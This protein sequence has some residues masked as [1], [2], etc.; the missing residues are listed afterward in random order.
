M[1]S[2]VQKCKPRPRVAIR[3]VATN[4]RYL[5]GDDDPLFDER[6]LEFCACADDKV[7]PD[8]S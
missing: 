5:F 7:K 3:R 4:H 2:A 6:E 8:N 1:R